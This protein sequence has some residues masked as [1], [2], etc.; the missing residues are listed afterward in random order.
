MHR[1]ALALGSHRLVAALV[2]TP[3]RDE[4]Q[5]HLLAHGRARRDYWRRVDSFALNVETSMTPLVTAIRR[6]VAPDGA[7][8]PGPRHAATCRAR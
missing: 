7:A 1:E 8:A 4:G 5:G 3:G 6:V 2:T